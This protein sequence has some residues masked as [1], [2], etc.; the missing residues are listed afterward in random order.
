MTKTISANANANAKAT[1]VTTKVTKSSSDD[2][3]KVKFEAHRSKKLPKGTLC[4]IAAMVLALNKAASLQGLHPDD[5]EALK[6]KVFEHIYGD[7]Y[8]DNQSLLDMLANYKSLSPFKKFLDK[9]AATRTPKSHKKQEETSAQEEDEDDEDED[10]DDDDDD[11]DEDDEDDDD[12]EEE[13][14]K[15]RLAFL[16]KKEAFEMVIQN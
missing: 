3:V 2:K 9:L 13:V 1:K 12:D 14:E 16:A 11:D 10:D 6:V 15:E 8:H 4:Q 7:G 5:A